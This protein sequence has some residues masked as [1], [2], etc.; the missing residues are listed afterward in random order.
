LKVENQGLFC[1]SFFSVGIIL[2]QNSY[3][4]HCAKLKVIRVECKI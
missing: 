2:S 1:D 4:D 3:L